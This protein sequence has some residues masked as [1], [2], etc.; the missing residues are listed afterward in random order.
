MA[1]LTE[2]GI[3]TL[4]LDVTSSESIATVK[5]EIVRRTGGTLDILYNNAGA[6]KFSLPPF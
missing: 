6:R 4:T 3:E 5:E 1:N 2:K